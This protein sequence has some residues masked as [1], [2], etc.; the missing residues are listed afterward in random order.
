MTKFGSNK[1]APTAQKLRGGY[2]TPHALAEF[3][4]DWAIREGSERILEPSCGDGNFVIE[5][6]SRLSGRGRITAVEVDKIEIVKA[7][8]R[9][10][11]WREQIAWVNSDFFEEFPALAKAEP[12]DV[13]VGNPPF[14]RF[15]HFDVHA[16][17]R[18]FSLLRQHGYKPNGLANAWASFVQLAAE[19][20]RDGGRLAMVLPAEL[21]QVQY[22]AE[23]R[24]RLPYMFDEIV[25]IGFDELVFPEI[26]Q[27]VVLLLA[28][29]RRQRRET[30][31]KL[32]TMQ[33]SNGREL[34]SNFAGG[35]RVAHL[36]ERHAHSAMK[37]TSLFLPDS[38]FSALDS[39]SDLIGLRRLGDYASVDVGIVTGRNSFFVIRDEHADTMKVGEASV[40]VVGR[41]SALRSILFSEEDLRFFASQHP[42]KLLNLSGRD[43]TL[44]SEEL[45]RY[46][47]DGETT[48]INEGYKCRIRHR[49]FDVPSVY[50]PE[51]FLFRQ[52]HNAPLLVANHA[53]ATSTDTIHRVRV[54][55]DVNVD[56]LCAASVNSLTFAW[57]EVCGR[58]YGGGVL[59]LEPREAE[60][61]PIPY[62]HAENIDQG[63][64]DRCLRAGNLIKALDH[65]DEIAL[66]KG[67][68]LARNQLALVRSAWLSLKGRRQRRRYS[69]AADLDLAS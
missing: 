15:Q 37:W 39:T 59:E 5:A 21:L 50:A 19:L 23:L 29:G 36:P 55:S 18:A 41:T 40:D 26:Q 47:D 11:A 46:I 34:I 65:S 7:Q 44:F 31:G 67:L 45:T 52:I 38:E 53:R 60:Q 10:A 58:S 3:L 48:R 68:G 51:A 62:E 22:A 32:H 35:L 12:F 13:I 61:L 42:S 14:I 2:Y 66:R 43:R 25:I 56:R 28:E 49:W 30:A 4:S 9:T 33:L 63:Y 54:Q 24:S 20:L 8:R 16:R 57:A 27:E 64:V 69:V 6:A 1:V 17:E